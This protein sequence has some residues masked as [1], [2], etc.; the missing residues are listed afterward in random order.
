[1]ASLAP[2]SVD[3]FG[4]LRLLGLPFSVPVILLRGVFTQARHLGKLLD[5]AD[6][7]AEVANNGKQVLSRCISPTPSDRESSGVIQRFIYPTV[8]VPVGKKPRCGFR[9]QE[10]TVVKGSGPGLTFFQHQ[11]TA[12]A[13]ALRL[14]LGF[15]PNFIHRTLTG[16]MYHSYQHPPNRPLRDPKHGNKKML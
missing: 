11:H 16:A 3:C 6:A 8:E 1:M 2:F 5:H 14:G 7:L 10:P 9:N 15:Q 4:R 13:T 12:W